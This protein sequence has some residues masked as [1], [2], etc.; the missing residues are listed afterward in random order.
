M[1]TINVAA[2]SNSPVISSEGLIT[3]MTTP[4]HIITQ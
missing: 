4:K 3:Y 1:T 2:I